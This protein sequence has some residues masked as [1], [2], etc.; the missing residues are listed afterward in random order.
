[1]KKGLT[2]LLSIKSVRISLV[3]CLITIMMVIPRYA[4]ALKK[5]GLEADQTSFTQNVI[6]K[7]YPN[8]LTLLIKPNYDSDVVALNL[9]VGIGQLYETPSQKGISSLMQRCLIYGGTAHRELYTIYEELESVGA[10]WGSAASSD[11]GT[12]WSRVTKPGL[13]KVLEVFFDIIRNPRFNEGDLETGKGE[14]IQRVKTLEDQPSNTVFSVFDKCFYGNHPYSWPVEGSI[15]TI[16]SLKRDDLIEWYRKTYIPNNM[17]FTVVGNVNPA[18]IIKKFEDVFGKMK[19]GR[20]PKKSSQPMPVLEKDIVF[21]QPQ[22]IQGAYLVLG[23]PAPSA[24]SKDAPVMDL[25]AV[26]LSNRLYSELRDKRGLVYHASSSYQTM[27]GPSAITGI[28]VTA[29]ENYS[30][31]RDGIIAEF[32]KFC[33]EP[34]SP[35]ELQAAKKYCKGI[36]TMSQGTS[37]VQ[38]EIVG[39]FELLGYGYKYVDLYPELIEKVT[40]EDIQRVARKYFKH[41]VLAVV[42]PEGSV[43]E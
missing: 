8:G 23:Y 15:E 43:E 30:M 1:M 6:K 31:V 22:N 4:Q 24:R 11:Y 34:V 25:I 21:H 19:K 5:N 10:S 9:L 28:T 26:T 37:A 29:P 13:N 35:L 40:P 39:A 2:D 17:V 14:K 16:S 42:A 27:V 20:L 18:E 36:V 12:V 3:L 7:V 32:K 41:Y 38:G 33:D